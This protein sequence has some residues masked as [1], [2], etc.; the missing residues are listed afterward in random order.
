MLDALDYALCAVLCGSSRRFKRY[1]PWQ[2]SSSRALHDIECLPGVRFCEPFRAISTCASARDSTF[3]V[4]K[5]WAEPDAELHLLMDINCR[6]VVLPAE[7][8][9]PSEK[10]GEVFGVRVGDSVRVEVLEGERPE[11]ELPVVGLVTDFAGTAVYMNLGAMNR[12]MREGGRRRNF[13][14]SRYWYAESALHCPK[15]NAPRVASILIKGGAVSS[16]RQTV[17]ENV[18]RMRSFIIFFASVIAV[19]VVFNSAR[20]SL[21]ERSRELAT[22]CVIGFTRAEISILLLGE[23][24]LLTALAIP[25]GLILGYGLAAFLIYFAYDT[26]LFRIPLIIDR[27]TYGF[28]A[29][30]TMV[31]ALGSALIVRAL[32]IAWI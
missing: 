19:G 15:K 21:A 5:Y 11:V 8:L 31:A 12:L 28:A 32:F 17:A 14:C 27:S 30:V 23:L 24:A 20:I 13:R 22:L 10:L 29:I 3:D 2:S 6:P 7:G 16:F 18:L 1:P 9:V 25:I 26:E 4:W